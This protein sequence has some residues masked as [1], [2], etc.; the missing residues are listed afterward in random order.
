MTV[1]LSD[2]WIWIWISAYLCFLEVLLALLVVGPHHALHQR[3]VRRRQLVPNHDAHLPNQMPRMRQPA[4][5]IQHYSKR[6]SV[7]PA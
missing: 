6:A 5:S 7:H 2:G 3:A 1:H 4:M